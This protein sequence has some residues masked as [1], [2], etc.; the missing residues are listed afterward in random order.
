MTPNESTP[1]RDQLCRMIEV[2]ERK[3]ERWRTAGDREPLAPP[4][5][6]KARLE[7]LAR[8]ALKR[9]RYSLAH[10]S[11]QIRLVTSKGRHTFTFGLPGGVYWFRLSDM[12]FELVPPGEEVA[13]VWQAWDETA[14]SPLAALV[15]LNQNLRLRR[16]SNCLRNAENGDTDDE[17]ACT[18]WTQAVTFGRHL[19]DAERQSLTTELL[20]WIPITVC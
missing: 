13:P 8:K 17:T 14:A 20:R 10:P 7:Q 16:L 3:L 12:G 1:S 9:H 6:A 11:W 19:T 15:V 18:V 5:A 4:P 2:A